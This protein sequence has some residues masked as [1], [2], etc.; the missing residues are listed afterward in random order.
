MITQKPNGTIW[1]SLTGALIGAIIV[2]LSLGYNSISA[3]LD[4]IE[5]KMDTVVEVKTKVNMLEVKVAENRLLIQE[6]I[7][8]TPQ[9]RVV[10]P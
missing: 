9:P 7:A 6:H 4:K 1:K 3:R 2:L 8:G 10:R 5:Q